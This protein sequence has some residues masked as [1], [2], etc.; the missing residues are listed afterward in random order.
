LHGDHRLAAVLGSVPARRG[1]LRPGQVGAH[2]VDEQQVEQPV[3]AH[4]QET[5]RAAWNL[6]R[7]LTTLP[8]FGLLA[9]ALVLHGR[10]TGS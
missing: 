2:H 6:V 1:V 7:V 8:A 5:R 9:W 10:I 4:F 3:R